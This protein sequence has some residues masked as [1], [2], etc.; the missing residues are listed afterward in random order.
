[1]VVALLVGTAFATACA[2]DGEQDT[3]TGLA[4]VATTSIWGDVTSEVMGGD[5]IVDIVVPLGADPHDYQPSPRQVASMEGADLVIANGLGLEEGLS[6]VLAAI[7]ADGANILEVA[8][9]VEPIPFSEHDDHADEADDQ[10]SLDPHVWFDPER[11]AAA[12]RLIADQ[13]AEL[14]PSID[15]QARAEAYANSLLET[16]QEITRILAPVPVEQRKLVTNHDALGYF[17]ERYGFE[18]IGVVIPGGSTLAE[19]SSAELAHLVEI[20]ERTGTPAIFAETTQPIRLADAVAAEVG[21]TVE[22]VELHTGSLGE[23]DSGAASLI[24]MLLT[25]ARRIADA[26]SP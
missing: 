10:E 5:G 11:V 26:L 3:D 7:A 23:A 22:V 16:D 14:D 15:W 21:G 8:E 13:L 1:M 25:N 9:N 2:T 18:V 19:P 20:I 24:E 6:D 4:V 12:A 17:A